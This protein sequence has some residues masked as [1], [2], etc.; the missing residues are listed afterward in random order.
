MKF[1]THNPTQFFYIH[2]YIAI[3]SFFFSSSKDKMFIWIFSVVV[4][5]NSVSWYPLVICLPS[6]SSVS[7]CQ[8]TRYTKLKLAKK[9][10][11]GKRS[12]NHARRIGPWLSVWCPTSQ[13]F[14]L[15]IIIHFVFVKVWTMPAG[16]GISYWHFL[17]IGIPLPDTA[18][19]NVKVQ[20]FILAAHFS[21]EYQANI[22]ILSH[23]T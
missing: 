6:R 13:Y 21:D 10:L 12:A 4:I 9:S 18:Y 7:T 20:L 14:H 8:S 1:S 3:N 22:S 11:S 5:E 2:D 17:L 19:C 16:S 23:A 15:Y